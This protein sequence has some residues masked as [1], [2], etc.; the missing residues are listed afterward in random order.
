[1][2]W[3]CLARVPRPD[4]EEETCIISY[5]SRGFSSTT[6]SFIRHLVSPSIVGN[7]IPI[8]CNQENFVLTLSSPASENSSQ[9]RGGA[10]I[11]P[12][13]ILMLGDSDPVETLHT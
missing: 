11:A 3:V 12:P 4:G 5:N 9:H 8:L 6:E 7:K 13:L 2:E 1:M 10:I